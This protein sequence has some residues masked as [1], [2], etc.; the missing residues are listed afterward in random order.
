MLKQHSTVFDLPNSLAIDVANIE[1]RFNVL[2]KGN[3]REQESLLIQEIKKV[4]AENQ[5][6][7][8]GFLMSALKYYVCCI[9]KRDCK[10][11][12]R[13]AVF[14]LDNRKSK[15]YVYELVQ[16]ITSAIE[17]LLRVITE[18]TTG[19]KA[20]E[21][22][23]IKC[24]CELSKEDR[25]KVL[26]RHMSVKQKRKLSKKRRENYAAM[27]PAKKRACLDSYV[28]KYANMDT[29]KKKALSVRKAEKHRL[30]ESNKKRDLSV[31]KAAKYRLMEPNKK[32]RNT[33]KIALNVQKAKKYRL[34][35]P[36]EKRALL[37]RKTVLEFKKDKY[38]SSCCFFTSVKSFNGNM[39]I[40]NTCHITMKKKNKLPC[41]AVHNNLAVYDVPRELSI[42]EKLE[43]ILVSQRIVFQKII[44]MPK[45]QQR[46]IKGAICNVQVTCEE[47]YNVLPRP[48]DSSGIIM[49]KLKRKL[50]FRGH[51]YFQAV[52]PQVI[53]HALS[54]LQRNNPLYQ[55]VTINLENID[56]ELSCLCMCKQQT[57]S[58][59]ASSPQSETLAN[60][61]CEGNDNDCETQYAQDRKDNANSS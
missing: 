37:Y 47:T 22:Q 51:V 29:N 43:Q 13:Y 56:P 57:A 46:K 12:T 33:E 9:F 5:E 8:T 44:V 18:K 14:G 36:H 58:N 20:F 59:I 15:G 60:D 30:M 53:L 42:L 27:E 52:R 17:L 7:N 31:R 6:H 49:I 40:C 50:Q 4:I 61:S 35:D 25:Q 3:K 32:R 34:M 24:N 1:A 55:N 28:A 26:R 39:Y 21:I 19:A 45:G 41:Q 38:N 2:Y 23:F 54:W 48:P 16:N 11:Q 10:G